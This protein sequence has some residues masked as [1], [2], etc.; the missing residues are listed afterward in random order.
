[1]KKTMMVS[2]LLVAVMS[3]FAEGPVR[4]V[5][6]N[7][8]SRPNIVW[9][10]SDDHTRQAIG[11]YG[12]RLAKL[13]PTPRIDKLAQEGMVFERCYVGNSICAPS[14]ATLLTGKHSHKHG[15]LSNRGGFNHNQP[16]FQKVLQ[17]NGYQTAMIG[18]IHLNGKMQGFDYWEVLPGQGSYY[19]PRFITA[20]G[21]KNYTG[22]VGDLVTD[23]SLEWLKNGRDKDK[24]FM[25]MVHHKATHR[26]WKCASRHT[27]LYDGVEIPE[28]DTPSPQES[29]SAEPADDL[30]FGEPLDDGTHGHQGDDGYA[31]GAG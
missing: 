5:R 9:I 25:L 14:R 6:G 7:T 17:K 30:F 22:Y 24:P 23:R 29:R 12:S 1:M 16:Q 26:S 15:K 8:Q 21:R 28:P 13:D 27:K 4:R 11:A 20:N 10:F 31:V 3:V 18:K 2:S 19:Q